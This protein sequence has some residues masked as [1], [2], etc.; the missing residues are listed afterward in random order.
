M[1]RTILNISLAKSR[2]RGLRPATAVPCPGERLR[3]LVAW[4]RHRACATGTP[5]PFPT[6]FVTSSQDK[7]C[8]LRGEHEMGIAAAS[9]PGRQKH[10]LPPESSQ[11]PAEGTSKNLEGEAW[12]PSRR[13]FQALLT[14]PACAPPAPH[15]YTSCSAGTASDLHQ[16]PELFT[17]CLR[18]T[19]SSASHLR[20][21]KGCFLLIISP[22]KKVVRVG[23]S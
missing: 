2:S 4:P 19:S 7:E 6:P 20:V 8:V 1:D 11:Q 15:L 21:K 17:Q 5:L 23:Y 10:P 9:N 3:V 16:G 22:S 13:A 12:A 14:A 18:S